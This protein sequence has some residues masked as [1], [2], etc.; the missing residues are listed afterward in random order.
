[1]NRWILTSG[2]VF[3]LSGCASLAPSVPEGYTGPVAIIKDSVR[4]HGPSKAEFFYLSEI[5]DR[6]IDD[7]R[8]RTLRTNQGRGFNMAPAIVE[9][10]VAAKPSTFKIIGRTEYAAPILA[11]TNTVYQVAGTVTFTPEAYRNYIV[12]GTLGES[13]SAVWVE[14]EATSKVVGEKVEL[15]GA[16]KLGFFEK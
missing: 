7:S 10:N 12:R 16:A 8:S 4:P 15:R 5:D 13:Y 1:M 2:L 6:K 14:D 3:F 9:R 11:L